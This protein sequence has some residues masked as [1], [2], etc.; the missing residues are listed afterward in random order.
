MGQ[1]HH[2]KGN[3]WPAARPVDEVQEGSKIEESACDGHTGCKGLATVAFSVSGAT[4]GQPVAE[5]P[6]M[7]SADTGGP[8]KAC[9]DGAIAEVEPYDERP[10]S[11]DRIEAE[12]QCC[13]CASSGHGGFRS[14]LDA[15][16]RIQQERCAPLSWLE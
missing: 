4:S 8:A 14:L 16:G 2:E 12:M 6:A 13:S 3:S 11:I 15:V 9:R 7:S 10:V 1:M 5:L